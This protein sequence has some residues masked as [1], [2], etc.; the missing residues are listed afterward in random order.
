MP[1]VHFIGEIVGATGLEAPNLFAKWKIEASTSTL[2]TSWRVL[3]GES[4][5]R[6]WLAQRGDD[7]LEMGVW[8]EPIDV[9]FACTSIAGWPKM[10]LEI[11]NTDSDDQVD[12]AGYGWCHMPTTPGEHAREIP[13]F[14][15]GGSTYDDIAALFVGGH[16][17]YQD[18]SVILTPDSRAGHGVH[19]VGIVTL[20][21]NVVLRGF[22][23]NVV[24]A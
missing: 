15:P 9:N 24:F 1:E 12:L 22:G 10:M 5:G 18:P 8:N 16:P 14:R 6:T 13:V 20:N 2:A 3:D 17:R 11:Y 21:V 23:G 7:N 4:T 19:S